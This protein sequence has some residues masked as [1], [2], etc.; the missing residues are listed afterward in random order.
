MIN[1]IP[2]RQDFNEADDARSEYSASLAQSQKSATNVFHQSQM[3][4]AYNPNKSTFVR[5]DFQL[6]TPKNENV[7][8]GTQAVK[9]EQSQM[10]IIHK[11]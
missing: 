3:S 10:E 5:K 4:S 11:Q 2:E 6:T 7:V 9:L 1:N 8:T